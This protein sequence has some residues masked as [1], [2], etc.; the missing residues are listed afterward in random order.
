MTINNPEPVPH[1][2][3]PNT[4]P[5]QKLEQIMLTQKVDIETWFREQWK[6]TPA[7]LTS[8]VD[9][10]NAGFKVAPVDTNLYPAGFNNLNPEFHP[11]CIQA[12]QSIVCGS[13]PGCQ[14]IMLIPENHTRNLFYLESLSVLQDI[15][16]NAGFEVKIGCRKQP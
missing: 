3:T 5:L 2:T 14:K 7:P 16:Q 10:R 11:M 13:M 12:A 1:L 15:F 4:L 8:S 6:K 9:I